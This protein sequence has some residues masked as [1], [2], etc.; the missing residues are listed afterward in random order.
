MRRM[1]SAPAMSPRSY[2]R[3]Q[4]RTISPSTARTSRR[5]SSSPPG[6]GPRPRTAGSSP[7]ARSPAR[8]RAARRYRGCRRAGARAGSARTGSPG[9]RSRCPRRGLVAVIRA[10]GVR[11]QF[12][13]FARTR[14]P[15]G[16][17]EPSAPRLFDPFTAVDDHGARYQVTIRDIGSPVL[18]WTL[19]F[20]GDDR[21]RC[22]LGGDRDARPRSSR[23]RPASASPR[24]RSTGSS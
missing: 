22:H 14:Q 21:V 12:S 7:P 15:S 6:W 20:N 5:P 9:S 10:R 19:A 24:N 23:A 8:R 11:P 18:G 3:R 1:P 4:T 13:V 17:W 16:R 2:N